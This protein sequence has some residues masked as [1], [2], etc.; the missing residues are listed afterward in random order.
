MI[1][2]LTGSYSEIIY[3]PLPQDDPIR[4]KPDISLAK[5]RLNWGPK[6]T[7]EEGLGQVVAYFRPLAEIHAPPA[8]VPC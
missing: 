6:V 4:R 1:I 3:K 7:M 8:Q 5:E 2:E